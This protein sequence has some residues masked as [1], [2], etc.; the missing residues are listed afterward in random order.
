MADT[1]DPSRQRQLLSEERERTL[2]EIER[3]K[4]TV[5]YSIEV[6]AEEGDPE[7]W[8]REKTLALIRTLEA[9][10]AEIDRAVRKLD[11]GRYGTCERCG[12][13]IGIE[14]LEAVPTAAFCVKCKAEM[15]RA[16][17]LQAQRE[18]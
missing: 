16:T 11:Q 5:S 13:P 1:I 12:Q 7:L 6:V 15:E 18:M 2:T 17:R 8:E 10:V 9:K 4:S 14:R 3:L